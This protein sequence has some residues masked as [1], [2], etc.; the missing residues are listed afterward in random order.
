MKQLW[1]E[2]H[3]E[4]FQKEFNIIKVIPL[5]YGD[6]NT[7]IRVFDSIEEFNSSNEWEGTVFDYYE[8]KFEELNSKDLAKE[9]DGKFVFYDENLCN[10][11]FN[12][13][14]EKEIYY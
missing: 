4:S 3:L 12:Y 6:Y 14:C 11:Y 5:T 10:L 13:L 2:Q 7:F 1:F 9:I 8:D